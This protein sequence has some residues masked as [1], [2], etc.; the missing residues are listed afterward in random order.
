M[1]DQYNA[2]ASN[3]ATLKVLVENLTLAKTITGHYE[4]DQAQTFA[5]GVK[6]QLANIMNL[7]DPGNRMKNLL[8]ENE[9][10][11]NRVRPNDLPTGVD[12][13]VSTKKIAAEL[14]AANPN[15]NPPTPHT[16]TKLS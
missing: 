9:N 15:Q 4:H 16:I 12:V 6:R 11:T 14:A 7:A 1:M 3:R 8:K 13:V 10:P 5:N 2:R